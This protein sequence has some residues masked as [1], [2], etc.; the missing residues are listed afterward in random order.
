MDLLKWVPKEI[1]YFATVRN[2][3]DHI[4]SLV[5]YF[6]YQLNNG[7]KFDISKH[8]YTNTDTDTDMVGKDLIAI[9]KKS[10]ESVAQHLLSFPNCYFNLQAKTIL[11]ANY[12]KVSS[13]PK[14]LNQYISKYSFIATES[15]LLDLYDA[16]GFETKPN[17]IS[18]NVNTEYEID[19][20]IFE[21]KIVR[22]VINSYSWMDIRLYEHVKHH[23]FQLFK[24]SR[25]KIERLVE[26]TLDN[27]DE[28]KYL[29]ANPDIENA[30]LE[31]FLILLKSI[32]QVLV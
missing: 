8:T 30:V 15:N 29:A 11:G 18:E 16:F 21:T 12:K 31:G 6:F 28:K 1:K 7:H 4:A 5:N 3:V 32:S 19:R 14:L 26:V 22:S 13:N 25:K 27:F 10:P 2:P 20:K 24:G 23:T 9:N 17:T